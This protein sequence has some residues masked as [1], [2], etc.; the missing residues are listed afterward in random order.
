MF[1]RLAVGA[2]LAV[3]T[4]FAASGAHAAFISTWDYTLLT[5]FT[6]NNTFTP[7]G[8]GTQ[9]ETET[10]V[11]WGA[12]GG[13]VFS[14]GGERSGI[15]LADSDTPP[16]GNDTSADP[17]TGQVTTNGFTLGDIGLGVWITHHNNELT[18]PYA[19]LTST[20][21]AST[22]TLKP[23]TPAGDGQF[24]P[25]TIA[26]PVY[27]TETPNVE[28]CVAASPA[29]NPCN[30]IF[31]L[32]GSAFN[33]SFVYDGT[34]YFVSIFPLLGNGIAAFPLLSD[35]QCAAAGASAGCVGFTTVE[36]QDTTVRFGFAI[37]AEPIRVHDPTPAPEPGVLALLG[38]ALGAATLTRRR[39]RA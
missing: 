1:N 3:A 32:D 38:A 2:L 33:Q 18:R 8:G 7:H 30:D 23:N 13:D 29:G 31:A 35:A 6:G 28:P 12:S 19:T 26:F 25:A 17:M 4:A 20:E 11:S 27:F 24:G 14:V 34:T 37:T 21:I 22:L 5:I 15:T 16:G 39:Q 36:G 10:Q 9:V